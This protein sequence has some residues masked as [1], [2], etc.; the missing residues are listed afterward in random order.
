MSPESPL[1]NLTSR[2]MLVL[3]RVKK[4]FDSSLS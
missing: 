4:D 3:L 2:N 1:G